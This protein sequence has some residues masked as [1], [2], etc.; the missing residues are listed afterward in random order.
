MLMPQKCVC[1]FNS[2]CRAWKVKSKREKARIFG[3][4]MLLLML[5]NFLRVFIFESN[6]YSVCLVVVVVV[7]ET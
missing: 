1:H 3:H 6:L 2:A 4:G 5:S 7:E